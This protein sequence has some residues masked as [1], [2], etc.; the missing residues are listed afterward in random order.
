MYKA[1]TIR[2]LS[3]LFNSAMESYSTRRLPQLRNAART[4]AF[5]ALQE[6]NNRGIEV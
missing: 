2:Q 1:M 4:V 6:L 3:E 5:R